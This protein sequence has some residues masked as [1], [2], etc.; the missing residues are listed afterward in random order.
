MGMLPSELGFES[1]PPSDASFVGDGYDFELYY[2]KPMFS[3]DSFHT[4]QVGQDY[5]DLTEDGSTMRYF[6]TTITTDMFNQ[7]D[8]LVCGR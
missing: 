3:G 8:E 5:V 1:P 2:Y 7:K 4:K 6:V